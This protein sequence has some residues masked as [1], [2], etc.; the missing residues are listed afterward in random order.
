MYSQKRLAALY[1]VLGA[2]FTKSTECLSS[3]PQKPS[4]DW[5]IVGLRCLHPSATYLDRAATTDIQLI[6][7][8]GCAITLNCLP[9]GGNGPAILDNGAIPS[10]NVTMALSEDIPMD[11]WNCRKELEKLLL[12]G[13]EDGG[14]SVTQRHLDPERDCSHRG[15]SVFLHTRQSEA[16]PDTESHGQGYRGIVDYLFSTIQRR[17]IQ[18]ANSVKERKQDFQDRLTSYSTRNNTPNFSM[19]LKQLIFKRRS[20]SY[21][22]SQC[23]ESFCGGYD[24]GKICDPNSRTRRKAKAKN[25]C[26]FCHPQRKNASIKNHCEK[27]IKKEMRAFYGICILLGASI[28]VAATLYLLHRTGRLLRIH[29]RLVRGMRRSRFPSNPVTSNKFSSAVFSDSRMG[30]TRG[31]NNIKTNNPDYDDSTTFSM[32]QRKFNQL[33]TTSRSYRKRIQDVFDIESLESTHEMKDK[34]FV[35]PRASNASVR[36]NSADSL[37]RA[38]DSTEQIEMEEVQSGTVRRIFVHGQSDVV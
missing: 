15:R 38:R 37:R 20:F 34:V 30:S 13:R 5:T 31:S 27:R 1:A 12:G 24:L 35:L 26:E 11:T 28:V 17:T 36:R 6:D 19:E 33:G 4:N 25:V 2:I 9:E 23:E 32:F 18:A 3:S 22:V 7:R 8:A 21:F 29:C 10:L 16:S 14:I